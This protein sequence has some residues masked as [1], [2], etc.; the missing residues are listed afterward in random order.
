MTRRN[1]CLFP[2]TNV[3]IQCRPLEEFDWSEWA[4]FEE[5]YL[6]V[7]R[8]VQRE[9]DD[10]KTR[11]NDR[12]AQR[13]RKTNSLFRHII[14]KDYKVIREDSPPVK[15]ILGSSNVPSNELKDHLDYSKPDNE[16]VGFLYQYKQQYPEADVRL[17]TYDTGA[18]A[19]A[20]SLNLPFVPVKDD[21][22]LPP[23]S[24]QVER[25]NRRLREEVNR[26]RKAEP[27]FRVK[28]VDDNDIE[29]SALNIECQVY[30]PLTKDDLSA[31]M[32]LIRKRFPIVT[33]FEPSKPPDR[34]SSF[35]IATGISNEFVY[36]P[37]SEKAIA[38]YQ[39]QEYPDWVKSCKNELSN[40]H[41]ALQRKTKP[42]SFCFVAS[43]EGTRPGRDT[44]VDITARGNFEI[45]PLQMEEDERYIEPRLLSPPKPP[46]VQWTSRIRLAL[47]IAA[48]RPL[49]GE[50][51]FR[52]TARPL[53]SEER[54]R[55]SIP[56]IANRHF[57][58]DP[59]TF[60]YKPEKPTMPVES[61]SLECKQW[62]HGIGDKDFRGQISLDGDTNQICGAVEF[63]IHAENLSSPVKKV[64]PIRISIKRVSTKDYAQVL[65]EDLFNS[66]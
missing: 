33:D 63:Q 27:Q 13:A 8:T 15:L 64:L 37:D 62:R 49:I 42:P 10:Q 34:E 25:E 21:W 47:D 44:L 43:N 1:L 20:K 6:I 9:I 36:T 52:A 35:S 12:V 48:A 56:S 41:E 11:G 61:F 23:E 16:I 4:D 58:G 51:Y 22:L 18:M 54:F 38:K 45:C 66:N 31:F 5:V 7:C 53:I 39:D 24:N 50:E 32:D 28:C 3:F 30:E 57:Q 59:N 65:I 46:R 55:P 60:Y 29:V 17:L 19:T 2:D 14:E 26:L 40:L